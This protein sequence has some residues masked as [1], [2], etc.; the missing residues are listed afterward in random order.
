MANVN[1]LRVTPDEVES[2]ALLGPEPL[3]ASAR[4]RLGDFVAIALGADVLEYRIPGVPADPRL[5]MRS[6]HSGLT[7]AETRVPFVLI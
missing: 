1:E 4:E 6:H 2:I 7:A 3:S 5:A